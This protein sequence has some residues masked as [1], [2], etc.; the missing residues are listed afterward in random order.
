MASCGAD[1]AC[2]RGCVGK[3]EQ[4]GG[5]ECYI[6]TPSGEYA[7]DKVVLFLADAFGLA[8]VNNK[9]SSRSYS[10]CVDLLIDKLTAPCR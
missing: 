2:S 9:V 1:W 3:I 6:A 10:L 4:I 8:L 5:I 7:K